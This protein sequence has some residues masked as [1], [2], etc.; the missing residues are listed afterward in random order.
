MPEKR[1]VRNDFAARLLAWYDAHARDLPW[2]T[3]PGSV[4]RAD[5]YRVWLSEIMLQQTTVEA[6]KP[7]FA[8]FIARWPDVAALNAAP[9]DEVMKAWAGLGYYSRARNL[10]AAADAVMREH[11]GRFPD[12]A[13]ALKSLPGVGDYTANAIAAIAFNRAEPVVDGNVERVIARH[14]ALWEP[15]PA[16][17]K[18]IRGI[19]TA[20]VPADRP[21]YFAQ[22]M[23]DLGAT[24]C[25]PKRAACD[26]CPIAQDC[27]G[28]GN[29]LAFPVRA[30][31]AAKPVRRAAAFVAVNERGD[32]LLRN[33]PAKG[34]LAGMS[35]PPTSAFSSRAD[36]ATGVSAAPFAG[37]WRAC[38]VVDHVFTHFQL[39]LDIWRAEVGAMAAPADHWW[40]PRRALDGEALPSVMKKAIA[41]ALSDGK[42][43]A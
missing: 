10:K 38:G 11:G 33:R 13:A 2:R 25:A 5:P 26:T 37:E 8:R 24:I 39:R 27:A 14:R 3:P 17:K 16:I 18:A 42:P 6:A 7:Y 34:L 21:G 12:N 22:G 1:P 23:M 43:N 29:P 4:E 20:L 31:K 15:L 9:L 19:V 35:E 36:G 32:V 30:I 28:R 41:A 40:T